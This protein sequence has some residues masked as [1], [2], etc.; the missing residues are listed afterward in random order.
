[1]TDAG[2]SASLERLDQLAQAV[3]AALEAAKNSITSG[4]ADTFAHRCAELGHALQQALPTF[5]QALQNPPVP[6]DFRVKLKALQTRMNL[7][8][9]T[10]AR[11]AASNQQ[12]LGV[13]FPTDQIQA[14]SRLGQKNAGAG[15]ASARYLKA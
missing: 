14:Y 8:Q 11:L 4:E 13:L 3:E 7:L 12:A 5:S 9:Q 2:W 1:M 6:T 10:Q 15:L